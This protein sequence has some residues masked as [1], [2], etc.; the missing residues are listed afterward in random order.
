MGIKTRP[1]TKDGQP[2]GMSVWCP[3]CDGPHMF[4]ER[5]TFNGSHEAPTFSPSMRVDWHKGKAR[6]PQVCH[7]FMVDGVWQYLVDCT[8]AMAGTNVPAPDWPRL[9]WGS[10][11]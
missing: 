4:D 10:G 1:I 6:V 8:H 9:N 2:Y 7:S 5:W 11:T 3:A